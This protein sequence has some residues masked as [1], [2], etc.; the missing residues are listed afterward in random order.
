[1][2]LLR[3]FSVT[4]EIKNQM[5]GL[6]RE[7]IQALLTENVLTRQPNLEIRCWALRCLGR[8]RRATGSTKGLQ[9]L[10]EVFCNEL[11][12]RPREHT[13]AA[14]AR[15]KAE[16]DDMERAGLFDAFVYA[17]S[18]G[19]SGNAANKEPTLRIVA[20]SSRVWYRFIFAHIFANGPSEPRL[21][22][23]ALNILDS[24][25]ID[26]KIEATN[27]ARRE[28]FNLFGDYEYKSFI[29]PLEPFLDDK[30]EMRLAN[31]GVDRLKPEWAYVF[32]GLDFVSYMRHKPLLNSI[33][34]CETL[35]A[36][37]IDNLAALEPR[38]L[39]R[40]C[41]KEAQQ[42]ISDPGRR[43]LFM[44]EA[45]YHPSPLVRVAALKI[46]A[47]YLREMVNTGGNGQSSQNRDRWKHHH[48]G[49]VQDIRDLLEKEIFFQ[50]FALLNSSFMFFFLILA[51]FQAVF[52]DENPEVKATA[53]RILAGFNTFGYTDPFASERPDS[54]NAPNPK[55]KDPVTYAVRESL[56]ELRRAAH[57]GQSIPHYH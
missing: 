40:L 22:K 51:P 56:K 49:T 32:H 54:E 13:P 5:K 28:H 48:F 2:G 31:Q 57:R 23:M 27:N 38:E 24:L 14:T 18:A 50:F 33:Y 35:S 43:L 21:S 53:E 6:N 16:H 25:P 36:A 10:M 46:I 37:L 19:N 44:N 20:N 41:V 4:E 12:E 47:R 42:H 52:G 26:F 34:H 17:I 55:V 8:L 11:W 9:N 30:R 39:Y 3:A 15:W 7:E 45:E 29:D 1:M